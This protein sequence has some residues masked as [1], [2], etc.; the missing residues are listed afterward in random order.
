M[1]YASL[2]LIGAILVSSI[3]LFIHC[4]PTAE[5]NTYR[6]LLE[7]GEEENY[8]LDARPGDRIHFTIELIRGGPV[9][10]HVTLG[11]YIPITYNLAEGNLSEGGVTK[12]SFTVEVPHWD[13]V[14]SVFYDFKNKS[15]FHLG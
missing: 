6:D 9:S 2:S 14:Y 11:A 8:Q 10:F 13:S 3:L 7:G 12:E 4:Q 15:L 1:R 5:A